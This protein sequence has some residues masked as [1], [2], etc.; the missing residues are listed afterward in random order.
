[1]ERGE[2]AFDAAHFER[3]EV[4]FDRAAIVTTG[5]QLR[6]VVDE[7]AEHLSGLAQRATHDPGPGA[8]APFGRRGE[9]IIRVADSDE[10]A[11]PVIR[12][13]DVHQLRVLVGE[14]VDC[15]RVDEKGNARPSRVPDDVLRSL[16]AFPPHAL[17]VIDRVTSAP[18]IGADGSICAT[19]GLHRGVWLSTDLEIAP[20]PERPAVGDAKEA[21]MLLLNTWLGD[22]PFKARDDTTRALAL[23]L[24]I[25]GRELIDGPVPLFLA[26]A[27]TA[28][29]GKGLLCSMIGLAMTG[30]SLS[31]KVWPLDSDEQRKTITAVLI[32]APPLAQ[33]DNLPNGKPW[34]QPRSPLCSLHL[35]GPIVFLGRPDRLTYRPE[36]SGVRPATTRSSRPRWDG[37][38]CRSRS[39]LVSSDLPRGAS[40]ACQICQAG[41]RR[42]VRS[43]F[44]LLL[45][46]GDDGSRSVSPWRNRGSGHS[47]AGRRLSAAASRASGTV[48]F[49]RVVETG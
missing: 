34:T 46:S 11:S 41:R 19:T 49:L 13:V 47:R 35:D 26:T 8:Q 44:V 17:P 28:G 9:T 25:V 29:T 7:V 23:I 15:V 2:H 4:E 30:S 21:E 48:A 37:A 1:M 24:T 22:F 5:R 12:L 10:D 40:F 45:F 43:L 31:A 6:E 33:L 16:L 36:R 42:I 27:P 39:M 20:I 32:E 3:V 38:R 18:F 14:A